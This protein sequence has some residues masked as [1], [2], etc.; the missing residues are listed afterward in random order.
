MTGTAIPLEH[1]WTLI[2]RHA[3]GLETE[4]VAVEASVG[5]VLAEEVTA[6]RPHPHEDMAAMDGYAFAAS[7]HAQSLKCIGISAAGENFSHPVAEGQCVRIFTGAALPPGTNCVAMQEDCSR[8]GDR[9]T[10]PATDAGRFTRHAGDDFK[11]S[12]QLCPA[13]IR[14]DHR[15]LALLL[16]GGIERV[17]VSY[18]VRVHLIASGTELR[19]AGSQTGTINS[20]QPA[21]AALLNSEGATI[22]A[23][24]ALGDDF[25]DLA[26]GI[27]AA[28]NSD[29]L[30]LTGGV[31]VG[32]RDLIRPVLDSLGAKILFHGVMMRP[33]KPSLFAR[34]GT[35]LVL[36]LP[37]NP[38]SA[39]VC[40]QLLA[41]P[42]VRTMQGIAAPRPQF[43]AAHTEAPL[44]KG[45][46]RE[47]FLRA[48]Y[49]ADPQARLHV[50]AHH[51]Q[52]SAGLLA[53]AESNCLIRRPVNAPAAPSGEVVEILP[54]Q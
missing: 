46:P 44:P 2:K 40:G 35:T 6:R 16:A 19:P 25:A 38:V 54:L 37:G 13:G 51:Q 49:H 1:A 3:V 4:D 32:D 45:G 17:S 20:N 26:A 31:S 34:L 47:N 53:L 11:T 5:R 41:L 23:T 8:E 29:L 10:V 33:G 42:T 18:P 52:D 48:T 24:A 30:I 9:V 12:Q 36:G 14:I 50:A 15:Q 43:I 7:T 27:T 21:L 28:Q 39:M 22:T